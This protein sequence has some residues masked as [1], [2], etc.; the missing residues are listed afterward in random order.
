MAPH[1]SWYDFYLG[2]LIRK[3]LNVEINYL[4][5]KELFKPPFGWYFKWTG[6]AALDRTPNQNKVDAIAEI[7][8]SREIFRLAISPEGTHKRTT[9]WRTGF[10]FIAKRAEISILRVAFDYGKKLVKI[11]QPIYTTINKEEDLQKIYCFDERVEG[12]VANNFFFKY[13]RY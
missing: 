10:Y 1:T 11:V 12:K 2:V 8:K 3:I 6:G 13:K 5:K 7:I 4:A 9:C